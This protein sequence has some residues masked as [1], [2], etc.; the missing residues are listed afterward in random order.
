V[1]AHSNLGASSAHRWM[2]CPGSVR[3]AASVSGIETSYAVEGTVAH[4]LA[5]TCLTRKTDAAQYIG[6]EVFYKK[7]PHTVDEEMA[8][9]VQVYVD[10]V[11]AELK[12]DDEFNIETKFDL[13][14]ITGKAG[15]FGT[16]DCSL[17][18]ESEGLL[19]VYDYKHGAGVAVEVENNPQLLYYAL[20]AAT[21]KSNRKLNRVRLVVVQPRCPHPKGP[22]RSWELDALTLLDWSADLIEAAEATEKPDAPL[23]G[24]DHCRWCPA[25]AIC[26]KLKE[27]AMAAAA[28]DFNPEKGAT[29]AEVAAMLEKVP[30]VEFW[31]QSVRE[32]AY[33]QA[34][35]GV[36]I[37]GHKL[38]AKR[39]TRKWNCDEN[40]VAAA[41]LPHDWA[42]DEIYA[43][44]LM[45]PAQIEKLVGK[46]VYAQLT[47]LVT[48]ESSGHALVPESD[49]RPEVKPSAE[50]DFGIFS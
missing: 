22:V 25:S 31:C 48:A 13:Q 41:L 50:E 26:P 38:V 29:P 16:N 2:A 42:A 45:S 14:A 30:L 43:K 34:E 47:H 35:K 9:A 20:G 33:A 12:P 28:S 11:R 17:Y 5:E 3:L 15:L 40:T 23:A 21:R 10:A 44:K 32:Y 8:E 46:E 36:K 7:V 39:A 4:M 37:P 1:T 18:R 19:I 6:T 24:G 27:E 49:K